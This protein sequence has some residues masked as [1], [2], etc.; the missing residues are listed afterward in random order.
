[1]YFWFAN[2]QI[3]TRRHFKSFDVKLAEKQQKTFNDILC[4]DVKWRKGI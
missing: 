3:I 2:G 4:N 1:M